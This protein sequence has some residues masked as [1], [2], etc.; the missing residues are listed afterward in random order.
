MKRIVSTALAGLLF[1]AVPTAQAADNDLSRQIQGLKAQLD[2]LKTQ[3]A[4]KTQAPFSVTSQV[5]DNANVTTP[6]QQNVFWNHAANRY[7]G[8]VKYRGMD[9]AM[10]TAT[11]P[12]QKPHRYFSML[13]IP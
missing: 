11:G 2:D 7:C 12:D 9:P 10:W 3:L 6:L 4:A 5:P 8:L 1:A 13:C